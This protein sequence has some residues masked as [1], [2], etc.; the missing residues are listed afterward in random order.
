MEVSGEDEFR[1]ADVDADGHLTPEELAAHWAGGDPDATS[2]DARKYAAE[3]TV[4]AS[5]SDKDGQLSED[6]WSDMYSEDDDEDEDAA[7]DEEDDDDGEDEHGEEYDDDDEDSCAPAPP[8]PP[9]R[10]PPTRPLRPVHYSAPPPAAPPRRRR[11]ARLV[12]PEDEEVSPHA[13]EY[14]AMDIDATATSRPM[15]WRRNGARKAATTRSGSTGRTP[16]A[17]ESVRGQ[18]VATTS[19]KREGGKGGPGGRGGPR[20]GPRRVRRRGHRRRPLPL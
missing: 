11:R 7:A 13:Q 3:M 4:Q 14:R 20:R 9:A 8:T 19:A 18:W 2:E 6:E 5:D 15:K 17:T 10:R 1:R 12:S 16:T